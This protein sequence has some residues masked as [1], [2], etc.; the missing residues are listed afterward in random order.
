TGGVN[1]IS[2]LTLFILSGLS[3]R[4]PSQVR[5]E[6]AA[7]L[8]TLNLPML[9]SG[10][11]DPAFAA[12]QVGVGPSILLALR[13]DPR[14]IILALH[15]SFWGKFRFHSVACLADRGRV[16]GHGG[17]GDVRRVLQSAA[18]GRGAGRAR[19]SVD[20]RLAS[21]AAGLFADLAGWRHHR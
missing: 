3:D 2:S 9:V 5:N 7:T 20:R 21:V 4:R 16:D 1:T 19:V 14:M 10:N 15:V 6:I 11:M 12:R 18:G 8:V 13:R 17:G